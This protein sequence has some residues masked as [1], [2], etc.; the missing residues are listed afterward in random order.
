MQAAPRGV[1]VE[2]IISFVEQ[3]DGIERVQQAHVWQLAE[4]EIY[5]SARIVPSPSFE[6]SKALVVAKQ[7]ENAIRQR[8]NVQ[9]ALLAL[10]PLDRNS[11][12]NPTNG[13]E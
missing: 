4:E 7:A 9:H 12:N 8:F 2:E 1:N 3:R 6:L 5:F 13:D 11:T 10:D